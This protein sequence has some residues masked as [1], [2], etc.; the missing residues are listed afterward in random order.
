MMCPVE[1]NGMGYWG[2]RPFKTIASIPQPTLS[3]VFIEEAD[4]RSYNNGT[5]VMNVNPPGWVD[6]FAIFHGNFSSFAFADG[7]LGRAQVVGSIHDQ[8]GDRFSERETEFLL[9]GG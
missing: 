2:V 3:F 6:P 9:V 1:P 5:W 7:Q 8:S 4:P